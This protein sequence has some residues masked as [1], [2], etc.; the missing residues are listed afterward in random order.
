MVCSL[1]IRNIGVACADT[2]QNNFPSGLALR[3][4]I[5]TKSVFFVTKIWRETTKFVFWGDILGFAAQFLGS[6]AEV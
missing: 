5:Y 1:A 2:C 3:K 4:V 6:V